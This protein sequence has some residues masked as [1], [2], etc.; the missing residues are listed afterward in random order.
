MRKK[1]RISYL[2]LVSRPPNH[3]YFFEK[4]TLKQPLKSFPGR[5]D[6]LKPSVAGFCDSLPFGLE[7]SKELRA[8]IR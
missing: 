4:F 6:S 3:G 5:T 8:L 1:V 2:S 7:E